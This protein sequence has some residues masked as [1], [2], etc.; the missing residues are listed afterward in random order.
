M[1]VKLISVGAFENVGI[2]RIKS[3]LTKNGHECDTIYIEN[4][5][6]YEKLLW[7]KKS[8]IILGISCLFFEQLTTI[9]SIINY[10][11]EEYVEPF[12]FIGGPFASEFPDYLLDRYS[13]IN[14]VV[15]GAGEYTTEFIVNKLIENDKEAIINHKNIYSRNRIQK[16]KA[17]I[18]IVCAPWADRLYISENKTNIAYMIGGSGCPGK[19][20]FCSLSKDEIRSRPVEDIFDE[21]VSIYSKT[22]IRSF[23]FIDISFE[24]YGNNLDKSRIAKLCDLL[25]NYPIKFS[26]VC[27]FRAETFK[28]NNDDIQLLRKLKTAGFNNIFMGLEAGNK[29]DLKLYKKRA[30]LE[31][32]VHALELFHDAAI[33]IDV[34]YIFYNPYSNEETLKE[35]YYFLINSKYDTIENY[36]SFLKVYP[37]TSIYHKLLED[38]LIKKYEL[39]NMEIKYL[40]NNVYNIHIFLNQYIRNNEKFV[41]I[42][43]IL[44]QH[45]QAILITSPLLPNYDE[46]WFSYNELSLT[47]RKLCKEYFGKLYID[48]DIES[49]IRN[50]K[51]FSNGVIDVSNKMKSLYYKVVKE[52][53]RMRK[54]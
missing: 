24:G 18:D 11:Y 19:C 29:V 30:T 46:I 48:L 47:S 25:I 26:I 16:E 4:N 3:H 45:E 5:N 52:M 33:N 39:F 14:V 15:L 35:N 6:F 13:N 54:Y 27:Q 32:N 43:D 50:F 10:V 44:N 20:S 40:N 49:C 8:K 37:N 42:L 34:G 21:M 51:E 36:L 53:I 22:N 9:E 23:Y 28:N 38:G 1:K 7:N 31:D 17:I 41:Q 12:I 2:G